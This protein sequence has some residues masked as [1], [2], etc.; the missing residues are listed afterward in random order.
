MMRGL[1]VGALLA[2]VS[3]QALACDRNSVYATRGAPVL[4]G[5]YH[6]GRPH[7]VYWTPVRY[8]RTPNP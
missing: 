1:F 8:S 7:G 6:F 4:L 3:V 5:S 2:G